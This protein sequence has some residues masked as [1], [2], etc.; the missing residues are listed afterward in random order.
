M[1]RMRVRARALD[2][3]G[4]QQMAGIP[5]AIHELFKNAHDAY[6]DSV[7]V[8]FFRSSG[9]L[10]LWDDGV[11][12]TRD[13]F[14]ERW[15]TLGTESKVGTGAGLSPP[16]RDPKKPER[17][18]LGEKGIGRLAIATIGPQGTNHHQG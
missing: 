4:R 1:P 10:V 14:V 18:I 13:D 3:L 2:M 15:L 11:G 12:M 16:Y 9:I 8:D 6:A 5:S 7:R 17:P